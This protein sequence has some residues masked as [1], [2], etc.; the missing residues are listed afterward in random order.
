MKCIQLLGAANII[1][2]NIVEQ[3]DDGTYFRTMTMATKNFGYVADE[4]NLYQLV[5]YFPETYTAIKYQDVIESV[6]I[7]INSRQKLD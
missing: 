7:I 1:V 2:G 6:E 5:I 4:K 3:D